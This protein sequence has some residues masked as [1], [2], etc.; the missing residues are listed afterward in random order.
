M[1]TNMLFM[2]D[3]KPEFSK[4][5]CYRL[6]PVIRGKATMHLI[7]LLE[8]DMQK[9]I[10]GFQ[11]SILNQLGNQGKKTCLYQ[12]PLSEWEIGVILGKRDKPKDP[13]LEIHWKEFQ[14]TS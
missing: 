13:A 2:V 11:S 3:Q 7:S 8:L 1:G 14:P 6:L 5:Q 4:H 12:I 10:N 9:Y